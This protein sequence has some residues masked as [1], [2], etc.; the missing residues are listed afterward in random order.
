MLIVSTQKE[1]ISKI[2][3]LKDKEEKDGENRKM[4]KRGRENDV[5]LF[6][7]GSYPSLVREVKLSVSVRSDDIN[8]M[9][10]AH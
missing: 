9:D 3:A 7:G 2:F 4:G 1:K 6:C 10:F 5:S 8:P